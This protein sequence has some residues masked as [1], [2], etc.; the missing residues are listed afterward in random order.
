MAIYRLNIKST[1][2]EKCKQIKLSNNP[3]YLH[4]HTHS[5]AC[6]HHSDR[7]TQPLRVTHIHNRFRV[8]GLSV[9]RNCAKKRATSRRATVSASALR[10]QQRRRIAECLSACAYVTAAA[11]VN[12]ASFFYVRIIHSPTLRPPSHIFAP[13]PNHHETVRLPL[14]SYNGPITRARVLTML[15]IIIILILLNTTIYI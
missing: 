9:R 15:Y 5:E 2:N 10:T 3:L 14:F 4:T 8:V 6:K 13:N 7:H 1:N 11:T 12:L